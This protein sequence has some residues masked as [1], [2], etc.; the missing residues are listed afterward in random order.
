MKRYINLI[1]IFSIV[2]FGL[3]PLGRVERTQASGVF[4]AGNLT[5][6]LFFTS[7]S[8]MSVTDIQ[9]FLVQKG[10]VLASISSDQ[11]GDGA[12]GRSAAQIIYDAAT[13]NRTDFDTS[14]GYG[15][16]NPLVMSLNPEILLLTLEKEQSLIDGNYVVGS[17]STNSALRTAMGYGCPD[18]GDCNQAYSG[19]TNQVTYAAAQF[20]K[21]YYMAGKSSYQPGQTYT[22]SSPPYN[23]AAN[24]SVTIGNAATSSLYQYTPHVYNGNYNFWLFLNKWFNDAINTF[25]P[26][27]RIIKGQTTT[28]VYVATADLSKRWYLP[29]MAYAAAWA[30]P[31][32]LEV[33]SDAQMAAIPVQVGSISRLQKSDT[34]TD[35]FYMENG[36]KHHIA[37]EHQFP[38]WNLSWSELGTVDS[39]ILNQI[40]TGPPIGLLSKSAS[41]P[42]LYLLT[43]NRRFYVPDLSTMTEWGYNLNS[44]DTIPQSII[45]SPSTSSNLTTVVQFEGDAKVYL[46]TNGQ[47]LYIPNQ[48]VLSAWGLNFGMLSNVGKELSYATPE[49]GQLSQLVKGSG[50][51][52]YYISGGQKRYVTS[53]SKL[54]SKNIPQSALVTVS[55]HLLATLATGPNL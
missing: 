29:S 15:P 51:N 25:S 43:Y 53:W 16:S 46:V 30:I 31:A 33:L 44:I 52:V 50:P 5:N 47:R 22:I 17:S 24:Q 40:P 55:D 19:F 4:D 13:V 14:D 45:L 1:L 21:N 36:Y 3:S 26:T 32:S 37:N 39:S 12:G 2:L 54:V 6:N 18:S 10:S 41:Q 48:T 7:P 11:L 27:A 38:I 9:N 49:A 28:E 42:A 20:M 35:V 34:S 8:Q 23:A